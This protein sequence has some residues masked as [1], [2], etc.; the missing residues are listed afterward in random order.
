[1]MLYEAQR[2]RTLAT[3]GVYSWVRHPQYVGFVLVMF[4]FLLQWPTLLTLAM[5]PVLVVMYLRLA[6]REEREVAAAFGAE[7]AA[8]AA[9]VPAFFPR[10]RGT[11]AAGSAG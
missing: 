9:R 4:G 3:S 2:K 5:F 6:R 10:W 8:Y 1:K 11:V 7:Y